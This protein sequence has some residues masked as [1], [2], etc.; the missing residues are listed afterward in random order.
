MTVLSSPWEWRAWLF[1]PKS[2][3]HNPAATGETS[4]LAH[5]GLPCADGAQE[6]ARWV[7]GGGPPSR[8]G[9]GL[10]L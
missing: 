1:L 9:T 4:S 6:K 8:V 2:K 10:S 7:G 5:P 3:G